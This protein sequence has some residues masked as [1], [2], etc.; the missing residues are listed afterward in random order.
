MSR[1]IIVEG[2]L[3]VLLAAFRAAKAVR[4]VA[5]VVLDRE[6]TEAA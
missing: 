1:T 5:G 3:A 2:D 4:K 6:Q